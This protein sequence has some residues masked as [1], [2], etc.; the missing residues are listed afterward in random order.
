MDEGRAAGA[1][2]QRGGNTP[3]ATTRA[4]EAT[5]LL[6]AMPD[7]SIAPLMICVTRLGT[8]STPATGMLQP[9]HRLTHQVA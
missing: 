9:N 6:T 8:L 5:Q 2:E 4:K 3:G 7:V 1:R